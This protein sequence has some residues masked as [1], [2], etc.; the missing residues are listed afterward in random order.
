MNEE[1]N[2]N[3]IPSEKRKIASFLVTDQLL[4]DALHIPE[5]YRFLHFESDIASGCLKIFIEGD[6]L[7]EVSAGEVPENIRPSITEVRGDEQ[8]QASRVRY[9]WDWNVSQ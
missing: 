4:Q 6:G 2:I 3:P 5:G 8:H 7:P 1:N 9:K